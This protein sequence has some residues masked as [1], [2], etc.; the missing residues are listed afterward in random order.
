[1]QEPLPQRHFCTRKFSYPLPLTLA[2]CI[3]SHPTPFYITP[4][5]RFTE[6]SCWP[7]AFCSLISC[8]GSMRTIRPFLLPEPEL[9]PVCCLSAVAPPPL[10][11]QL[12]LVLVLARPWPPPLLVLLAPAAAPAETA[13]SWSSSSCPLSSCT[14]RFCSSVKKIQ[15]LNNKNVVCKRNGRWWCA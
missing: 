13:A 8:R 3:S 2:H 5:W 1:M 6:T 10:S 12:P 14:I 15:L 4:K 9:P 11:L 7:N